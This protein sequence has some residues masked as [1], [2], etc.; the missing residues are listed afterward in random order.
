MTTV[1]GIVAGFSA[2]ALGVWALVREER[3]GG[4]DRPSYRTSKRA[5]EVQ[6]GLTVLA[7]VLLVVSASQ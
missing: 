6:L 7:V 3:L 5:L 2:I 4:R 1:L